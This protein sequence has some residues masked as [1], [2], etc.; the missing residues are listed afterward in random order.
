MESIRRV[1]LGKGCYCNGVLFFSVYLLQCCRSLLALYCLSL[2]STKGLFVL[3]LPLS[4]SENSQ[5]CLKKKKKVNPGWGVLSGE[6]LLSMFR[7][8]GFIPSSAK[9]TTKT[10]LACFN[11]FL[12][13]TFSFWM[14][15]WDLQVFQ[16]CSLSVCPIWIFC[17]P[18][19]L[20]QQ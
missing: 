18:L 3:R 15:S 20:R 5:G 10:M 14:P 17:F 6:Y 9:Q 4:N 11:S 8:L 13:A 7:V 19:A 12:C 16:I 2:L 1:S